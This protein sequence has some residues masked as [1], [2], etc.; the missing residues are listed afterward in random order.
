MEISMKRYIGIWID[1]KR[2]FIATLNKSV[3]PQEAPEQI[4]IEQI[5][6]QI[7]RR[8]RLSGGSRTRKTPW[9]PQEVAVDRT[10]EE[11]QKH[12]LRQ[13]YAQLID[14]LKGADK[15]LIL[16]PGEAKIGLRK[17]IERSAR[18]MTKRI[19]GVETCDKMTER[20]IAARVRS[21]FDK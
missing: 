7:D 8:T 21:V 5:P 14:I 3:L 2:A 20:Q 1:H 18:D 11:R 17:Q 15:I 9:G 12:Q 19:V 10:I 13:F 4:S 6:S 16:G